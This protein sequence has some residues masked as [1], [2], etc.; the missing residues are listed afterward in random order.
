MATGAIDTL[1]AGLG[2]AGTGF[3][4]AYLMSRPEYARWLSRYL[5]LRARQ[6]RA[7]DARQV[8]IGEH[9]RRLGAYAN[10]DPQLSEI[11]DT[12]RRQHGNAR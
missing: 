9:I 10:E 7:R 2:S 3:G 5:D 6:A 1:T 4:V 12:V 11:Y 8:P